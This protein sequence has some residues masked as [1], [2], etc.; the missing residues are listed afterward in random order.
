[1]LHAFNIGRSAEPKN[2]LLEVQ[3]KG[4]FGNRAVLATH[5]DQGA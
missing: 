4:S 5:G 2:R 1:M 3:A